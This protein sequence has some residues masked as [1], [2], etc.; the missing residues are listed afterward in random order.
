[1]FSKCLQENGQKAKSIFDINPNL[2][3]DQDFINLSQD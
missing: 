1:L 3:D 2:L